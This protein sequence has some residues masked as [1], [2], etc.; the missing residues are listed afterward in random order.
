M[1]FFVEFRSRFLDSALSILKQAIKGYDDPSFDLASS[2]LDHRRGGSGSPQ[3]Y[4]LWELQ[5]ERMTSVLSNSL[6]TSRYDSDRRVN[7]H[8]G[9]PKGPT[10]SLLQTASFSTRHHLRAY[11]RFDILNQV[12]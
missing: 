1:D 12:G 5:L 9:W 6:T 2:N 10:S 4:S 3:V 11:A 7:Q 8:G